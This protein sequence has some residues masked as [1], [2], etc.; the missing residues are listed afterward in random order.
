VI[1]AASNYLVFFSGDFLLQINSNKKHYFVLRYMTGGVAVILGLTGRNFAAGMSGGIAYIFDPTGVFPPKCNKEMVALYKV[2]DEEDLKFLKNILTDFL[3]KTQSE[4]A[5]E[6]LNNW[7]LST[8]SF[9]KVLPNDYKRVLEEAKETKNQ[10]KQSTKLEAVTNGSN[11]ENIGDIE[12]SIKNYDKVGGFH[13]YERGT[14]QYRKA[15][16]RINDW[17]EIF[18][19]AEVKKHLK[20]QAARCMDCGVPFCQSKEGCPLGN[21]IPKWNDLVFQGNWKEALYQLMQ[22]NNFPEFTGRVCPAP[23]EG[24]CVVVIFFNLY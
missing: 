17:G 24:A 22:T 5:R 13:K 15:E 2:V 4:V 9:I 6:I 14:N 7:P 10:A 16:Q 23:C 20:K 8:Y 18:D 19:H 11:K 12:D 21:I 3:D 1:T